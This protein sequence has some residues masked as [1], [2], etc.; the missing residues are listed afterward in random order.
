MRLLL[1]LKVTGMPELNQ[2]LMGKGRVQPGRFAS[3][4]HIHI[5]TQGETFHQ[6]TNEKEQ[7]KTNISFLTECFVYKTEKN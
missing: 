7:Q 5:Y 1:R 6:L 3:Q 2:Q 4:S